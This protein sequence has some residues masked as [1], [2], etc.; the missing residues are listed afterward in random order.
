MR[1]TP[2]EEMDR[3]FDQMR[4]SM[5]VFGDHD[6]EPARGFDAGYRFGGEANLS[7]ESGEHG[8]VVFADLPGF[9]KEEIDL[10]FDEGV[11][12]IHAVHEMTDE[13]GPRSR[14]VREEV[15][16]PGD[17][18]VE[19]IKAEY[20]NGVLEVR[21]PTETEPESPSGHRIDID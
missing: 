14:H 15:S 20:H 4:R 10:R 19:E 5:W 7:L 17:V 6:G 9:E 16:V 2:F 12:S 13:R 8:Y 18:L 21:L 11:L 3:L 1:R